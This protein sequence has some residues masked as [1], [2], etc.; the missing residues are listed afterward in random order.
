[1]QWPNARKDQL[2][3]HAGLFI[4][5]S[6]DPLCSRPTT[7]RWETYLTCETQVAS[8]DTALLLLLCLHRN[9]DT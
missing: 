6:L 7:R 1:M 8:N 5:A 4:D 2:D 9:R 3:S